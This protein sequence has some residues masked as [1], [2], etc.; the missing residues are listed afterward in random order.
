MALHFSWLG[1]GSSFQSVWLVRFYV[2]FLEGRRR[3]DDPKPCK[4]GRKLISQLFLLD[5]LLSGEMLK[6]EVSSSVF[7]LTLPD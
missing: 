6:A 4:P 3:S 2:F 1:Q 7:T 5:V